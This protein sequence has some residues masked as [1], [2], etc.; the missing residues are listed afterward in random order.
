MEDALRQEICRRAH[1]RCEYCRVPQS[2]YDFAFP[3]DHIIA[4]Q[5]G[6]TTN[7]DNLA[8]CCSHCNRF[9]GPDI[10]SID[11]ASGLLVRLFHPR[12]D[13]WHE[14][15]RW[16]GPVIVGVTDVG[17]ATVAELAF[18]N[19]SRIAARAILLDEEKIQQ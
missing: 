10:A 5:H 13:I 8:L 19:P 16:N 1:D 12:R 11:N 4:R 14:H 17:R 18:N 15:F 9:K 3:I 6:G 7:S 2:A